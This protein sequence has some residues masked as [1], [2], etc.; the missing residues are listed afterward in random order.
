M[1]EDL[2]GLYDPKTQRSVANDDDD[3][4]E[5]DDK[6]EAGDVVHYRY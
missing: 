2:S 3:E 5:D 1:V 6:V 4:I